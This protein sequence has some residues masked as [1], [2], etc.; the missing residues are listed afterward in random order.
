M[1]AADQHPLQPTSR[2][3]LPKVLGEEVRDVAWLDEWTVLLASNQGVFRYELQTG[4]T[5]EVLTGA[6]VPEG[7]S[8]PMAIATDGETLAA[9]SPYSS[10]NFA[11]RVKDHK[12]LLAQQSHKVIA[13]DVGVRGNRVCFLGVAIAPFGEVTSA[14]AVVCGGFSDS[15]AE[16]KPLHAIH[17]GSAAEM[18]Y[19][20][21]VPPYAGAILIESNGVVDV[22]TSAEPGVYR[23]SPAGAAIGVLGSTLNE[24]VLDN[25]EDILKQYAVD[26]DKRY[27][28]LLNTRATID[29]LVA[30]PDGPSIVV[31][32]AEHDIIHW[33]LWYPEKAGGAKRRFR[34]GIERL[35]P[36]GH[37]RCNA[38]GDRMACVGSAPG[39][40]DAVNPRKSET[41][42][43]LWLFRLPKQSR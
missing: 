19:R 38:R 24:L 10:G 8:Q 9:V 5:K 33:E 36:F 12:R 40:V 29:G 15:W 1:V 20:A 22:I 43:I 4:A 39:K 2:Y 13:S 6:P 14:T 25:A 34:L 11:L 37:L 35:G 32:L 28:V 21:S 23:Y 16:L 31:R 17:T 26:V 3:R 41:P 7:L 42:P 27:R 18:I 30:T